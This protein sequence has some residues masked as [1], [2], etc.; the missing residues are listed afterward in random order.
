MHAD[1]FFV[2]ASVGFVVL[3]ILLV[4]L[5]IGLITFVRTINRVGKKVEKNVDMV[6]ED[7]QSFVEDMRESTLFRFIG[8]RRR[9]KKSE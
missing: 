4:V 5:L 3:A 2:I 9:K 8:G 7:V 1:I 6:G